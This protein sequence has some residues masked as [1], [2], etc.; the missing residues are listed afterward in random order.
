M[1]AVLTLC[2]ALQSGAAGAGSGAGAR[3]LHVFVEDTTGTLLV[4][5]WSVRHYRKSGRTLIWLE[6]RT[7]DA[8]NGLAEFKALSY[9]T[10]VVQAVHDSE[11]ASEQFELQSTDGDSGTIV[12]GIVYTRPTPERSL[13]VSVLDPDGKAWNAHTLNVVA[14]ARNGAEIPL[15]PEPDAPQRYVAR[16]V[17]PDSYRIELRDPGYMPV[18]IARHTTGVSAFVR[19][20]GSAAAHIQ[21]VD[22]VNGAPVDIKSFQEIVWT[23]TSLVSSPGGALA[24]GSG[25]AGPTNELFL[26]GLVAGASVRIDATFAAH[27]DL[28]VELLDLMPGETR[29]HVARVDR[30]RLARGTIVDPTGAPVA[31]VSV[32]A[33]NEATR[34]SPLP[35]QGQMRLQGRVSVSMNAGPSSGSAH[36]TTGS[37][38]TGG[39][40]AA[41]IPALVMAI[42]PESASVRTATSDPAGEFVL[43]GLA[44]EAI[45]L[46]ATFT[47]WH[48]ET[49]T[50]PA[51]A[52]RM[53]RDLAPADD[54]QVTVQAPGAAGADIELA[55]LRGAPPGELELA[56]QIGDG[57]WLHE[58]TALAPL[59]DARQWM[60]LRGLP[61]VPCRLVVS[62]RVAPSLAPLLSTPLEIFEFVPRVGPPTF[63]RVDL[64]G[65]APSRR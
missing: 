21:F 47:P 20:L 11:E 58:E 32:T 8:R 56:L 19:P 40:G 28:T 53:G 44:P 17:E 60:T 34:G 61:E 43:R 3:A 52:A 15:Q 9:G 62:R 49:L 6:T 12:H 59:V 23:Q 27:P 46:T 37:S 41:G 7:I 55:V 36:S 13:M 33:Q 24:K 35:V 10:S 45:E 4:D 25:D 14:V 42:A 29:T 2:L 26:A 16:G 50:F 63:V 22:A 5:G 48:Q 57:P 38:A 65:L 64:A 54:P 30:G 39:S 1:L 18:L 31:G 51:R